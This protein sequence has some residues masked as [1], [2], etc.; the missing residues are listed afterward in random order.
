MEC[1]QF[2]YPQLPQSHKTLTEILNDNLLYLKLNF[3]NRKIIYV[4]IGTLMISFLKPFLMNEFKYS[5]FLEISS[6]VAANFVVLISL[7]FLV[8]LLMKGVSL[9]TNKKEAIPFSTIYFE[10]WIIVILLYF[11]STAFTSCSNNK[12]LD[13]EKDLFEP[14]YKELKSQGNFKDEYFDS[15]S[16]IYSNYKYNVAF[17]AP[18]SWNYDQGVTEH[19][20]FRSYNQDSLYTFSINVIETKYDNEKLFWPNYEKNKIQL[21]NQFVDITE[22]QLNSKIVNLTENLTYIRNHK[23]LKRSFTFTRKDQDLEFE[24]TSIVQQVIIGKLNYTFGLSM[25]KIFYDKNPD[26]FN[27]MFFRIYFL[28]DKEK[29]NKILNKE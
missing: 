20:I 1:T 14:S 4:L 19:M 22:N 18:K 3:M 8:W 21:K 24:I 9:I 17:R 29:L 27:E 26:Y 5:D 23:S 11:I 28:T 10:S 7:T 16:N 13:P 2:Q 25:P 12:K 15:I 6:V